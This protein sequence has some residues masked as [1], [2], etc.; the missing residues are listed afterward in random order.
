MSK[1]SKVHGLSRN[2]F[3]G[4]GEH[5]PIQGG[6][7][8][9]RPIP[10]DF[11]GKPDWHHYE[12]RSFHS[13]TFCNIEEEWFKDND[14]DFTQVDEIVVLDAN[15]P[16]CKRSSLIASM[17]MHSRTELNQS[18]AKLTAALGGSAC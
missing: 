16:L 7:R 13:I 5:E 18:K 4:D 9:L 6:R 10:V 11:P 8:R 12:A 3:P 2:K 17:L 1:G 14:V 15:L